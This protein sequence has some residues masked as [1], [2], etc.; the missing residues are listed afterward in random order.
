MFEL[1]RLITN[2][3]N[4]L[5]LDATRPFAY[6]FRWRSFACLRDLRRNVRRGLG[7]AH[8]K[9]LADALEKGRL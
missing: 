5:T 4:M 6:G 8:V 3:R 1:C 9:Q 2:Q 7:A